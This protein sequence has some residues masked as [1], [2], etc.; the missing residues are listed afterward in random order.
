MSGLIPNVLFLYLELGWTV[1]SQTIGMDL[2]DKTTRSS[3]PG[4][5]E[6]ST[7]ELSS[8]WEAASLLLWLHPHSGV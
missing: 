5:A 8:T 2:S 4:C 6:V 3:N 7:N 1:A